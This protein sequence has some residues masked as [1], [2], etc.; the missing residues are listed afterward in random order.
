MLSSTYTCFIK[1][2]RVVL[3]SPFLINIENSDGIIISG[4]FK[5]YFKPE[6]RLFFLHFL[7]CY[8]YT[9][10]KQEIQCY[11]VEV[12]SLIF[13]RQNLILFHYFKATLALVL[14][15]LESMYV[16]FLFQVIVCH[17]LNINLLGQDYRVYFLYIS[18]VLHL[19]QKVQGDDWQG[20]IP[21]MLSS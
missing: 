19:V 6:P 9:N 1:F 21:T 4:D 8:L 11:T 20:G 14:L 5:R 2:K 7:C 3:F 18:L 16:V 15:H 13:S 10:H 12:Y 17:Q